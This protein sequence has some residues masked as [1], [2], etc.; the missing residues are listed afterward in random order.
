MIQERTW[1][2]ERMPCYGCDTKN[3]TNTNE[4]REGRENKT[5]TGVWSQVCSKWF[6]PRPRVEYWIHKKLALTTEKAS[7]FSS[8]FVLNR[9]RTHA[10]IYLTFQGVAA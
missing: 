2:D 9:S 10:A 4:P 6:T 1:D 5:D 7:G 3:N 8:N